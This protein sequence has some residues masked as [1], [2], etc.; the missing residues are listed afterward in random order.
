[1]A[2]INVNLNDVEDQSGDVHPDGE[3]LVRIADSEL[4]DNKAGDGQYINWRL[5][6]LNSDNN[7]PVYLITSLKP[8]ALWNLKNFV[9]AAGVDDL[10]LDN[11]D[12]SELHGRELFV[13]IKT[14]V[15]E[16]TPRNTV[17]GP[18]KRAAV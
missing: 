18:Y 9:K 17:S 7:R 12:T 6:V 11:F 2:V 5:K 13:N 3:A 1:M 14:E 10:V 16:N 15:Y 8:T 4:R